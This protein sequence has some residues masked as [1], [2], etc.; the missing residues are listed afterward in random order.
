M[1]LTPRSSSSTAPQ[2]RRETS[3]IVAR[4]MLPR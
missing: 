3:A 4:R 1:R 2:N